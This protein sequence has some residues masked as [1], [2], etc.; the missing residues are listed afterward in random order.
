MPTPSPDDL[1]LVRAIDRLRGT[2]I[3]EDYAVG[4]VPDDVVLARRLRDTALALLPG[5]RGH[6]A[7]WNK[8][9]RP[10]DGLAAGE[11]AAKADEVFARLAPLGL[12]FDAAQA[13]GAES[14]DVG[15]GFLA[16]E[17]GSPPPESPRSPAWFYGYGNGRAQRRRR[18][19]RAS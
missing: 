7:P 9:D 4:G 13:S 8:P 5:D 2:A 17:S 1:A 14:A 6:I 18:D 12:A 15:A 19:V 16:G 10:I 3:L 11:V